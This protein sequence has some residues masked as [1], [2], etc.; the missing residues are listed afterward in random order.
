[1]A[2]CLLSCASVT[3]QY[4]LVL[5]EWWWCSAAENVTIA[6]ASHQCAL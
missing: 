2:S 1:M 6:L 3:K 5:A 4:Y